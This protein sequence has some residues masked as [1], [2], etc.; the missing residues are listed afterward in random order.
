MLSG[1]GDHLKKKLLL[2]ALLLLKLKL[3]AIL[4]IV[5]K[6]IAI[7]ALKALI[8]S[9]LAITLVLGFIGYQLFQ[10]KSAMAM[11]P[12]EPSTAAPS[13]YD[14]SNWDNPNAGGP[15]ARV[16]EP[17]AHQ[18]AYSAYYPSSVSSSSSSAAASASI[19]S[20]AKSTY[21]I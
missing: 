7:K 10:K 12:V 1:R 3:K 13:T 16:W 8:L 2:P 17:A 9:K 5:V 18:M 11:A 15:Y 21:S 6:L 4:P 20:A 14:P 19:D